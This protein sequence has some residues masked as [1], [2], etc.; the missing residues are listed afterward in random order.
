MY[1]LGRDGFRLITLPS[2]LNLLLALAG[3]GTFAILIGNLPPGTANLNV[4][5]IIETLQIYS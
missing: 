2:A 4:E 1:R 3:L 5:G